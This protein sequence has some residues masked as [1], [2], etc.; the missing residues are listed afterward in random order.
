[1]LDSLVLLVF[2]EVVISLFDEPEDEKSLE[3]VGI[4]IDGNG[5]IDGLKNAVESKLGKSENGLLFSVVTEE[6]VGLGDVE[7]VVS[8]G[9]IVVV[10]RVVLFVIFLLL[11]ILS[12]IYLNP[13]SLLILVGN[14]LETLTGIF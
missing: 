12:I 8:G 11:F 4:S 5:V 10:T 6:V 14:I 2:V 7:G 3:I 9:V 1:M 13:S